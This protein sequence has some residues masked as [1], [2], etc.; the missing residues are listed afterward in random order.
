MPIRKVKNEFD[1]LTAIL[2]TEPIADECTAGELTRI[3]DQFQD[4][5]RSGDPAQLLKEKKIEQQLLLLEE[6][7]PVISKAIKDVINALSGMG[8]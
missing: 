3:R 7:N 2:E 4:A 1:K 5:I 6:N 8:I